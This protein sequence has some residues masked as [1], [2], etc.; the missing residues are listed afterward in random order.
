MKQDLTGADSEFG[1]KGFGVISK[2]DR[3]LA[4]KE[5]NL[6]KTLSDS[7]QHYRYIQ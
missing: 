4:E 2:F 6:R 7:I 3:I 1:R 5:E